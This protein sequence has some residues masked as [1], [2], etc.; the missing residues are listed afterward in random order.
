MA[1]DSYLKNSD[2]IIRFH[3]ILKREADYIL[4]FLHADM[5][6]KTNLKIK[7]V[8]KMIPKY[9]KIKEKLLDTLVKQKMV[10]HDILDMKDQFT[11]I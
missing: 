8:M 9:R 2:N 4:S 1:R 11:E 7:A 3:S 6:I 10:L 5:E